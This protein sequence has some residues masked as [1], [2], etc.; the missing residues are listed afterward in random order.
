[1]IPRAVE[2]IFLGI[3][4]REDFSYSCEVSL[5]EV[6]MEK[7]YDLLASN[8]DQVVLQD[9]GGHVIPRGITEEKVENRK[10]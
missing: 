3:S 10:K 1:M 6:Y 9:D 2:K 5:V 8:V 4:S 7:V